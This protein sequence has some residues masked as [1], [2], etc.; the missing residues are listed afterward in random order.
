ARP[1]RASTR[2]WRPPPR[3]RAE[4]P[5]AIERAT[6]VCRAFVAARTAD[7]DP[8]YLRALAGSGGWERW[9]RVQAWLSDRRAAF[10]AALLD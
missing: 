2:G 6:E 8:V 9:D 3:D 4:L 7:G 10:T 5:A 1:G